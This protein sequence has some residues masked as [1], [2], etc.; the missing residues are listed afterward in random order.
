M[1]DPTVCPSCEGDKDPAR[2]LCRGCRATLP[3]P[4]RK[5]LD[6]RDDNSTHRADELLD[7]LAASVP[8]YQIK[9]QA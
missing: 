9:V 1:T 6:K 2:Y 7:Q 8:L 3:A 5:A 4:T